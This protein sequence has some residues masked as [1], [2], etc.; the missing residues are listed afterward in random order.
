MITPRESPSRTVLDRIAS[1]Y[2]RQ[3]YEVVVEPRGADLPDFLV[4]ATPD[5]I[6]RR[7]DRNVVVEVKRSPKDVDRNQVEAISQLIAKQPGWQLVL[8]APGM[9]DEIDPAELTTVDE[10]AIRELI[11]EADAVSQLGM[12]P[13]ALMCAWAAA[14]AAARLLVTR[15]GIRS[16]RSDTASLIRTLV[17]EGMVTDDEFRLLNDSYRFRSAIAHGRSPIRDEVAHYAKQ[18]TQELIAFASRMLTELR[19]AA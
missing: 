10:A 9:P 7:Q 14:E 5:L 4:G 18:V 19:T 8:M 15:S 2:R 1:D 11:R 16:Q 6:A 12:P 17:S 13:A 3:G